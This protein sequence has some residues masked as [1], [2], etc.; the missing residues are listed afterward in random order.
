M[1]FATEPTTWMRH[2]SSTGHLCN[3][4][5]IQFFVYII[6]SRLRDVKGTRDIVARQWP[7]LHTAQNLLDVFICVFLFAERPDILRC[8]KVSALLHSQV[9]GTDARVSL[10]MKLVGLYHCKETMVG[11][12]L[13]LK[14]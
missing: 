3:L 6:K 11:N 12:E 13:H 7:R 1:A 5:C 10:W 8:S 9:F 4:K 14:N 2:Q